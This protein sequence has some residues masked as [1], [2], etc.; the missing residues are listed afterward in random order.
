MLCGSK[1]TVLCLALWCRCS[2]AGR[3][4]TVGNGN[5]SVAKEVNLHIQDGDAAHLVEAPEAIVVMGQLLKKDGSATRVLKLRINKAASVFKEEG[6]QHPVVCS[7]GDP[8]GRGVTEAAVMRKNLIASNVPPA[9]IMIETTS[10]NTVQNALFVLK[11]VGKGCKKLHLVTSDFHMPRCAYIYESVLKSQGRE[12]IQ[13]ERHPVSGGC[14]SK[15]TAQEDNSD[16]DYQSVNDMTLLERLRLE[17]KF[18]AREQ[19]GIPIDSPIG[20]TVQPLP[21][22]RLKGA[23]DEVAKTLEDEEKKQAQAPPSKS[24]AQMT[25]AALSISMIVTMYSFWG[26]PSDGS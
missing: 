7:G 11:M 9:S 2:C 23:R 19:A 17:K 12:D 4:E 16:G 10:K 6:G 21:A 20:M 22:S 25:S 13:L 26:L 5:R 14:P 3:Y 18:L 15:S 8:H 1:F 24:R